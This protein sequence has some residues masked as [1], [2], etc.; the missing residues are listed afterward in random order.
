MTLYHAGNSLAVQLLGLGASTFRGPSLIPSWR[1]G[2]P[3]FWW[4]SQKNKMRLSYAKPYST[5]S[6][7]TNSN[8]QNGSAVFKGQRPTLCVSDVIQALR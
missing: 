3:V 2:I 4:Y 1:N 7:S 6:S 5:A 8:S